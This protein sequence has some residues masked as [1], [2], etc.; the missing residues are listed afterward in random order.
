MALRRALSINGATQ[1]AT[2]LLSLGS[3]IIVSRLLTPDEIGIFS[4]SVSLI[5]FAHILRDFGVGQY[6]IQSRDIDLPRMRAAFTVMLLTSWAIALGIYLAREPLAIFYERKG[7]ADVLGL[8]AFNFLL[9]PFGAPIMSVLNREMRFGRVALVNLS[10]NAVQHLTTIACAFGGLGYMSPAWGSIAGMMS[11]VIILSL[12]RPE[13]ALLRPTLTGLRNVVSFGYK[14]SINSLLSEFSSNA[15]ELIFG[16]TLG[17]AAVAY[18]NRAMSV[19][20]IINSQIA[21]LINSAYFPILASRIRAGE[22]PA[23]LYAKSISLIVAITIPLLG[24]LALMAA[25]VIDLMFG[26]Q[27]KPSSLLATTLSFGAMLGA[28]FALVSP[29][30]IANGQV[31]H[32]LR[33]Q[34][35]IQI[36]RTSTLLL[37]VWL[38]L[39]Y[40]VFALVAASI[41]FAYPQDLYVLRK[42]IQLSPRELWKHVRPA[43]GIAA[44]SLI[45]PAI[46]CAADELEK[47]SLPNLAMIS[48]TGLLFVMSWVVAIFITRHPL[49]YEIERTLAMIR[50]RYTRALSDRT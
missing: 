5:G 7:V 11:N 43:Y 40:T 37:S 3:V 48:V 39:D 25:P 45:G 50:G 33:L 17:F 46:V 41:L 34:T 13:F 15:P 16:R 42:T 38:P 31:G 27:W 29:I 23:D 49:R 24:Y 47:L 12:I 2:F 14:S 20:N 4:V 21:R 9:I 1:I 19:L 22:K 44:L 32:L 6:L 28:P 8:I 18:F 26:A 30:L 36:V 35:G 10:N